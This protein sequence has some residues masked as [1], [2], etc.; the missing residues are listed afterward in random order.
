[1]RQVVWVAV[2]TVGVLCL[3]RGVYGL[4]PQTPPPDE[5]QLSCNVK[6]DKRVVALWNRKGQ[7]VCLVHRELAT[8]TCSY[9]FKSHG[10][11]VS[12]SDAKCPK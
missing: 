6:G 3:W 1:M 8:D 2:F 7:I 10:Q 4:H 5:E 11:W 12:G 9:V